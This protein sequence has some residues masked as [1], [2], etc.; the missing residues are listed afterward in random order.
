[1]GLT[2]SIVAS[3]MPSLASY[4]FYSG[5]DDWMKPFPE[6]DRQSYPEIFELPQGV[7]EVTLARPL[8][9][10]FEEIDVGRGLYVQDLVEDG[11]AKLSG[12]VQVADVLV[13]MTATKIVGAKYER[14]MIPARKFDFDTM[15]GAVASNDFRWGCDNVILMLERPGEADSAEVDT[16]LRF[17]EPPFDNPWKQQQ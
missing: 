9:I 17:F 2:L 10:V 12:Q 14:R 3:T 13:G 7:Y 11:N 4:Q 1:M 5:F 6:Q 8:G 16:F 15:A